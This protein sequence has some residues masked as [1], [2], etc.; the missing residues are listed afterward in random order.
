MANICSKQ[1][2]ACHKGIW[3]FVENC[4][5]KVKVRIELSKMEGGSAHSKSGVEICGSKFLAIHE[6]CMH[7][8]ICRYMCSVYLIFTYFL[9]KYH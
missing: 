9:L 6:I 8:Y 5:K 7:I 4:V 3:L 2:I 1:G